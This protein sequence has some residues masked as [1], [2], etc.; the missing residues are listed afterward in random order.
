[1]S[2]KDRVE[3]VRARR[4]VYNSDGELVAGVEPLPATPSDPEP[5][6]AGTREPESFIV[7]R[8]CGSMFVDGKRCPNW[9]EDAAKRMIAAPPKMMA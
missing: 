5:V 9:R 1:M 8:D 3:A 2:R 4:P 6:V 7:C